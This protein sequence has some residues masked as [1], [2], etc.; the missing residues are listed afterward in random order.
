LKV[1]VDYV[2]SGGHKLVVPLE[3][4]QAY[5]GSGPIDPRRPIHT[6]GSLSSR[7]NTSNSSYNSLQTK[8]VRN[9]AT[10]L[11]FMNSFTWSRSLDVN[12]DAN[13]GS[14]SY[15][16]NRRLAHGPSD[17]NIPLMNVS[18]FVYNLPFG[19]GK[20]FGTSMHPVFNALFG[21]WQ[22]SGIITMRSG[23]PFSILTGIDNANIGSSTGLALADV[24][25]NPTPSGFTQSRTAWFDVKAFQTPTL[26]NL[27]TSSRNMMR[28][29]SVYNVD[30]SAAKNFRITEGL[31]LQFRS[32][33][34]NI[35]N[36]T[37]F[38]VPIGNRTNANFGQILSAA[39]ARDIQFGLKVL[40]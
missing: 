12:S 10:G 30:F 25:S 32:E 36:H 7:E 17:Y 4:N 13:G 6:L 20:A 5:V 14:V 34:F 9:F 8:V 37:N 11:T 15:T 31:N 1:S 40:W 28:A 24:V 22:T 26:G 18:S 33:F 35:F 16:Y 39:G 29:P 2:G 19:K 38:G 21:G 3:V 23:Q 27:G